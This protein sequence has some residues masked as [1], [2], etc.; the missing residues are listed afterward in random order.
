[1]YRN[2]VNDTIPVATAG[3]VLRVHAGI[4]LRIAPRVTSV[5]HRILFTGVLHGAPVP[6]GG[7]QLVLEASSGGGWIEFVTDHDRRERPL[8]RHVPLQVPWAGGLPLP[9]P[10]AVRGL[11]VSRRRLDF[12]GVLER[13]AIRGDDLAF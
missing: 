12:V 7:K 9:C 10:L 13:R 1:V 5:D 4:A 6:P 2:H 11:P 8:Q 3:L